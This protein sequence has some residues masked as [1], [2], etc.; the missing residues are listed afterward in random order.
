MQ[1]RKTREDDIKEL[2]NIV[3]QVKEY[4]SKNNI[5]QWLGTYPNE[6]TFKMDIKNENSYVLEQD[7]KILAMFYI[8]VGND[9]SYQNIYEGKWLSDGLYGT[10]RRLAT[11][12]EAKGQGLASKIITF[13][14]EYCRERNAVSL[15]IDTHRD[16][17]SMLRFIEKS[18]FEECGIIYG[19]TNQRVAFEKLL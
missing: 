9:P 15:R 2:M 11:L 19:D 7:G 4:F 8:Y 16:N 17:K 3:K 18:G 12:E 6:E 10:I 13:C 14:E 1:I 5:K